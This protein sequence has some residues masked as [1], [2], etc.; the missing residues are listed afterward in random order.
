[1]IETILD[2]QNLKKEFTPFIK[3]STVS[4]TSLPH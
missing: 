4:V 2:P 3:L 1:M